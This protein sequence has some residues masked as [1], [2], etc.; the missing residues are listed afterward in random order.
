MKQD[1]S[2]P[3]DELI[4]DQTAQLAS[5][6]DGIAALIAVAKTRQRSTDKA[7][8]AK[9]YR[10][11][12]NPIFAQ[13]TPANS[14]DVAN[15]AVLT[16]LQ[17]DKATITAGVEAGIRLLL[18]LVEATRRSEY[19]ESRQASI[20]RDAASKLPIEHQYFFSELRRRDVTGSMLDALTQEEF[21]VLGQMIVQK[22][23]LPT[24]PTLKGMWN[25]T[26][27][28]GM[29]NHKVIGLT[30]DEKAAIIIASRPD[31]AAGMAAQAFFNEGGWAAA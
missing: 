29:V 18:A 20:E 17:R 2:T 8:A 24:H 13:T 9:A 7:D 30:E 14:I 6:Y 25:F 4:A 1:T 27:R 10:E 19:E 12:R 3:V 21:D 22:N 28:C 5:L 26:F 16:I 31:A 23:A 11:L 15:R